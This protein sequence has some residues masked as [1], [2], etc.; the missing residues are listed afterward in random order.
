MLAS[1]E[2]GFDILGLFGNG[3]SNDHAVDVVAKEEVMIRLAN[4]GVVRVQ[5]DIDAQ[6]FRRRERAR[7]H[8]FEGDVGRVLDCGLEGGVSEG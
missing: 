5:V 4:A 1:S 8:S 7:I 3:Q 6:G 2:R